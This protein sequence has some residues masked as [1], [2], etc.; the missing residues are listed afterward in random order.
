[1][2]IRGDPVVHNLNVWVSVK[3]EEVC[4]CTCVCLW[5]HVCSLC[6]CDGIV[7]DARCPKKTCPDS[8]L[9]HWVRSLTRKRRL[10]CT[11]AH[12][13]TH[14]HVHRLCVSLCV[15]QTGTHIIHKYGPL[16]FS[17]PVINGEEPVLCAHEQIRVYLCTHSPPYMY[18]PTAHSHKNTGMCKHWNP[19]QASVLLSEDFFF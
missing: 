16:R 7:P 5:R 3:G 17:R 13:H 14:T 15:A 6:G 2:H 18:T 19:P 4:V 1:M 8:V 9:A 10:A 12:A 11:C